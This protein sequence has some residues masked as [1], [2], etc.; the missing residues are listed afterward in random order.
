MHT[1]SPV[2]TIAAI[3]SLTACATTPPDSYHF[4]EAVAHNMAAQIINPEGSRV[5]EIP[6]LD[7]A[8]VERAYDR[9]MRDDKKDTDLRIPAFV[10]T[11]QK[12]N[13]G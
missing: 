9:L 10:I 5:A 7:G 12:G 13:G 2:I 11:N 8:R 1:I 6:P 4:G 3:V